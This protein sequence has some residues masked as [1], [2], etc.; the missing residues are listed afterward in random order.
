MKDFLVHSVLLLTT[1]LAPF[2]QAGDAP[3]GAPP[4]TQALAFPFS[5]TGEGLANLS[6]GYRRGAVYEGLLSVGVRG[7]L[8]KLVG[9]E[10]GSFLVSGIYPHGPSL[11]DNYVHDFNTLSNIDAN[12]SIRLYEMWVQQ[13]LADG[14]VSLRLGQILADAEFFVSDGASLFLNGAFGAIPLVSKNLNAPVF[15]VA[16]PGMRVRWAASD[17]ISVQA[18]VFDG[19]AG[20]AAQ[21][22][23]HGVDWNL[24]G[25]NGVLAITEAAYTLNGEK[26]NEGLRGV[27][28]LGAFFQSSQRNEAFPDVPQRADAGGYIVADQ[29]LW[30]KPGTKD[31]GLSGFFRIGGAPADRNIVPFYFDT[32]FN[33]KGLLPDREK[34]IAGI[35]F[36]YT[37]LSG[38]LRE[39]SGEPL[40][41]H[42]EAILEVTYKAGVNDWL[43]VQPDFQY[44][45]NPGVTEIAPNAFVV[46]VRFVVSF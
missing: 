16:A 21:E 26:E 35:G 6:G 14:K 39:D 42:H 41:S 36:N 11:T 33:Y 29:Q 31:Q 23:R 18:G 8:G 43:A 30:R 37:K 2:A 3:P 5:Y 45:I 28:K 20:D 40:G 10:G 46:G 17:S 15:P 32:G 12:D 24:N 1:A 25:D 38:N 34:D 19:D 44:I 22:N 7:D 27:Y 4:A 13:E 9:W